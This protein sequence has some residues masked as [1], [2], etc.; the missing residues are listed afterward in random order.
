MDINLTKQFIDNIFDKSVIP[1]L[2]EFIK[3][4][5]KSP[6]FDENWENNGLLLKAAKMMEEWCLGLSIDGLGTEVIKPKGKSPLLLIEIEAT[7]DKKSTTLIY[8]HL[9]KQPEFSG[10][11]KNKAPWK[12]VIENN[13]L[14][15]RGVADDGYAVFSALCAI[16]ALKKQNLLHNKF[17]ILIESGEESG[18]PDLPYYIEE[19]KN[20]IGKVELIIC[21]DSGCKDY[22]R[23]WITN[24]L[25]GTAMGNLEVKI[26]EQGIHSGHSG[27]AASSFRILRHV[28]DRI[29][30]S[31]TGEILIKE[32]HGDIPDKTMKMIKKSVSILGNTI[33]DAIPFVTG[34]KPV[35]SDPLELII[36]STWKPVLSYIGMDGIPALKNAGSVLRPDTSIAL[37]LRLPP[38]IDPEMA[39]ALMKKILEKNPPYNAKIT[40]SAIG[41]A[42]GWEMPEMETRLFAAINE[43]SN[44]FFNNDACFMGEGGSIQ[45]MNLL[46]EK[47]PQAQFIITGVLGPNS[48]AHGPNE[49]LHIPY[50]K[51]LTCALSYVFASQN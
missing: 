34:A 23:L 44:A 31:D 20:R 35:S 48:N 17:V 11:D 27:I 14:Y 26:L 12:P 19:Y 16:K 5:A 40:L 41:S 13:K 18:S 29:E 8:G 2:K 4:E 37:S 32:L 24:S 47:F 42:N 39:L 38:N 7:C 1:K 33:S 45:F 25:R 30:D 36:N 9:D 28:L 15:G 22:E 6:I 3:I 43:S 49:F 51:K 21:L 46:L 50:A 10:W